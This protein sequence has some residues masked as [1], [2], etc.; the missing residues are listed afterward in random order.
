MIRFLSDED[1]DAR[2]VRGLKQRLPNLNVISVHDIGLRGSSDPELLEFAAG[3]NRIILTHDVTTM[4]AH[5]K[6]RILLG[7]KMP[8]VFEVPQK[9]RIG[10][11]IEE[12]VFIA[13]CSFVNEW[14]SQIRF[15]PFR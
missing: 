9:I 14:A 6:S 5:A 4:T 12:L 11:A 1:F 15:L 3:E 8:G 13:E 10:I 7:L 2:I